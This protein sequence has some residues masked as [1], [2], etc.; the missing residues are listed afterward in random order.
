M[1]RIHDYMYGI[2]VH[3]CIIQAVSDECL[4]L[5]SKHKNCYD[6]NREA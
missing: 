1:G 4:T 2:L 6:S 3:L 5:K